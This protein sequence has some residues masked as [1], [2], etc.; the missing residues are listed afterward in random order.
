MQCDFRCLGAHQLNQLV[1]YDFNDHLTRI[2]SVHD[3]LSDCLLLY[4][5]D[6]L[7]Y[8]FE[9]DIRLEKCHFYFLQRSLYIRLG[10]AALAS[11]IF[12]NILEFLG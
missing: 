1:I 11:E 5:F 4:G 9:A 2:Q 3:V 12:E 8:Y 6:K 7:F 10:Q